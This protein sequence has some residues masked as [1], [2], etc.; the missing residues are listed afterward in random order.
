MA[1]FKELRKV[2]VGVLGTD[3]VLKNFEKWKCLPWGSRFLRRL[4][5]G[6]KLVS[7][8]KVLKKVGKW[9]LVSNSKVLNPHLHGSG[10]TGYSLL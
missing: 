5:H 3:K 4:G 7:Y 2:E 10:T 6:W 8:S 1:G 9:N